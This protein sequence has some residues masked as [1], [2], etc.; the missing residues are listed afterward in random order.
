MVDNIGMQGTI[1]EQL[2]INP[3]FIL[4]L[5]NFMVSS[6]IGLGK[7]IRPKVAK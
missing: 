6:R 7:I 3:S 5:G 1:A 4:P 2:K